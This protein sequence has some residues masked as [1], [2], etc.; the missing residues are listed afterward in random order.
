MRSKYGE[1]DEYHTS[2]I[3]LDFVS[4][5]GFEGSY[6]MHKKIIDLFECNFKYKSIILMNP[7]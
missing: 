3:I 1:F 2:S 5:E 6:N 7:S 4:P